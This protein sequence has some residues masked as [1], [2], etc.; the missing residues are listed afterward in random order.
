MECYYDV[1]VTYDGLGGHI[2]TFAFNVLYKLDL[3]IF[4]EMMVI[5]AIKSFFK[6]MHLQ[7]FILELI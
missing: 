4:R 1:K 5:K 6:G 2:S 3:T 7:E